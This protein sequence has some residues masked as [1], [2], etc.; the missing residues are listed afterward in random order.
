MRTATYTVIIILAVS[1]SAVTFLGYQFFASV[2]LDERSREF[3]IAP[4]ESLREISASLR[5]R[6]LV[7]SDFWFR[8]LAR[9]T[10]KQGK[11]LAGT[12]ELPDAVS[13]FE[14]IELLSSDA[15]RRVRTI[16]ILEGWGIKDVAAYLEKA[17]LFEPQEFI[18]LAGVP[19]VFG[20]PDNNFYNELA[21]RY[22]PL[23]YRTAS[24]P[25]EGYL[26]PDTYEVFADATPRDVME[27]MVAN[28]DAK[29]TQELRDEI[30]R[31]GKS[32]YSVLIIASIIE[33]EVPHEE[34]RPTVAGIF[35]SRLEAGVALQSDA[36]L[37]YLIGGSSPTLTLEQLEIDSA[38]NTYKYRGLPPTPIGNPGIS[39]IRAAV[40]P[41][42][43][44]YFYFLSTPDGETVFS[45]TLEEHN[46]AKARHLK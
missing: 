2:P 6:G 26:F 28:F 42:R 32:F 33:A 10:G 29:V 8:E 45:R 4:G 31:L 30:A 38:Y 43:T 24:A 17:G 16:T 40:Y 22:R 1:V 13:A 27:K 14:L 37:N 5:T 12:F 23:V 19:G 9:L 46:A 39:A 34:D 15:A 7:R 3:S 36:T 44:D 41:A 11:F 20:S 21:V 35:W 18:A 25:L